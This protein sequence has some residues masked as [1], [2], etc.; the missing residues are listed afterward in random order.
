MKLKK[1]FKWLLLI[2]LS[3]AILFSCWFLLTKDVTKSKLYELGY[4]ESEVDLIYRK[5]SRDQI[6]ELLNVD[7][8]DYLDKLISNQGFDSSKLTDYMAYIDLIEMNYDLDDIIYIVNQKI[9]YPY[10]EKLIT[11][12]H[13][14]YYI[15]SRLNR[16]MEYQIDDYHNIVSL[17]NSNRDYEYYTNI[18]STNVMDNT[19]MLVNKYY[20]LDE[21][22]IPSDLVN[23]NLT[24]SYS[25]NS[26]T[27]EVLDAFIK[28]YNDA[29]KEGVNLII[30][31]SYRSYNSQ[32]EIWTSRK[33]K[34]G[35]QSA[36][37]YAAR[38]GF[39]EHQT[40]LALD[41]DGYPSNTS[42]K[43]YNWLKLNAHKYGFILRYPEGKEEITGYKFEPWHYRYVGEELSNKIHD[44][45]L[46]L[47]EYYAF[48]IAN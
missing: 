32:N 6:D 9:E 29:K 41:I 45:N 1:K 35:I 18:K 43:A 37:N 10:S 28:M 48:Y 24:Y 46:T 3:L 34:N 36:D 5:L 16:Y 12:L 27:K 25:G 15:D 11:V 38:P 22:Y 2:F 31:S 39:S 20:Y 17:V 14:K 33:N 19:H 47:E 21:N 7:Y 8:K 44:K 23:V 40:G 30:N 4:T 26:C 13:D 42:E